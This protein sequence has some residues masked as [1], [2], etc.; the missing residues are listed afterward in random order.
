MKFLSKTGLVV[1]NT[2]NN[3]YSNITL[4]KELLISKFNKYILSASGFR[5]QYSL[6]EEDRSEEI[7]D[8][9]KII[10]H[11]IASSFYSFLNIKNPRVLIGMDSRPTGSSI[12]NIA[13]ATLI[14]LGC[15]VSFIFISSAPQA[16]AYSKNFDAFFYISASHNPIAHNGFKMGVD[17]GVFN[18]E[19]AGVLIEILKDN[20]KNFNSL[21]TLQ[22]DEN[23]MIK[24]Y[25]SWEE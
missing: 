10:T 8:E 17:G 13:I 11:L 25:S 7:S 14:S 5:N 16:M 24:V 1:A 19:Q 15:E 20:V 6:D 18:K 12:S 2:E 9:D 21:E 3:P 23:S 22:Y 4:N